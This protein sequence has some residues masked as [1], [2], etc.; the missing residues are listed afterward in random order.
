MFKL[1]LKGLS[2]DGTIWINGTQFYVA[3]FV[4][5]MTLHSASLS[6]CGVYGKG[7]AN[8]KR[9]APRHVQFV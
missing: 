8:P 3:K 4:I 9:F 7:T 2:I 1:D 5:E 6:F